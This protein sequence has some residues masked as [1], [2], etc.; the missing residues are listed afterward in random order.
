MIF[1]V[2]W[3]TTKATVNPV[4]NSQGAFMKRMFLSCIFI[5]LSIYDPAFSENDSDCNNCGGGLL[6]GYLYKGVTI[7]DI[8][9]LNEI[10]VS[11]DAGA[12]IRYKMDMD[13]DDFTDAEVIDDYFCIEFQ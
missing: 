9:Q 4:P 7:D 11:T 12:C 1:N 8:V 2:E 6:D 5:S 10:T 3:T 13:N